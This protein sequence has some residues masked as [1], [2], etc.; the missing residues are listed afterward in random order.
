VKHYNKT[1]TLVAKVYKE[2]YFP[3]SSFFASHLR[4]TIEVMLGVAYGSQEKYSL[5]DVDGK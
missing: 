5:M 2:R 4:G 3:N 1:T